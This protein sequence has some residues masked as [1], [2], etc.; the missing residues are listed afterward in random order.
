MLR[1]HSGK[2]VFP[3]MA[4]TA[5]ARLGDIPDGRRV[6]APPEGAAP[7]ATSASA[8]AGEF[9]L[10]LAPAP[11]PSGWRPWVGKVF[12]FQPD[13]SLA[14]TVGRPRLFL[15][16]IVPVGDFDDL[17][18]TVVSA[19][20]DPASSALVAGGLAFPDARGPMR[21]LKGVTVVDRATSV[22]TLDL[23]KWPNPLGFDP[24]ADGARAAEWMRSLLPPALRA[25]R[26]SVQWSSSCCVGAVA[27]RPPDVLSAAFRLLLDERLDEGRRVR[28]LRG[29]NAAVL[30]AMGA[31]GMRQHGTGMPVDPR[32]GLCTQ[33]SYLSPPRLPKGMA[34]PLGP[35]RWLE[36]PGEERA[37]TARLLSELPPDEGKAPARTGGK[38]TRAVRAAGPCPA[39]ACLPAP[40]DSVV[41]SL[42]RPEGADIVPLALARLA[43]RTRLLEGHR[44]RGSGR[45]L[46]CF[47]GWAARLV[48]DLLCLARARAA[49]GRQG[50][51][52]FRAWAGGVPEGHRNAWAVVLHSTLFYALGGGGL[53]ERG[54]GSCREAMLAVGGPLLGED[55]VRREWFAE[56]AHG[57]VSDRVTRSLSGER[58][59]WRGRLKCLVYGYGAETV[60]A[61]LGVHPGECGILG[62]SSLG[63]R[64]LRRRTAR[65][66]AGA[67]P[68][69]ALSS[70]S[71]GR[72]A[73]AAAMRAGGAGRAEIARACGRSESWVSSLRLPPPPRSGREGD[74]AA[75]A[76]R[77][78][79][80]GGCVRRVAAAVGRSS[81]WVCGNT[82]APN[83]RTARTDRI[84]PVPPPDA[85][86]TDA[87]PVAT[88]KGYLRLGGDT[89]TIS[90]D[91]DRNR[92]PS[93]K[94]VIACPR[95]RGLTDPRP[96]WA[97]A[98]IPVPPS[99]PTDSPDW[100]REGRA[101][102]RRDGVRAW[103]SPAGVWMRLSLNDVPQRAALFG[104][105]REDILEH[106]RLALEANR[107]AERVEAGR[108]SADRAYAA[109]RQGGGISCGIGG[110][111]V[112]IPPEPDPRLVPGTFDWWSDRSSELRGLLGRRD[113]RAGLEAFRMAEPLAF[114]AM[115][116]SAPVPGR[117]GAA[118]LR[119]AE[120]A[121]G[122]EARERERRMARRV[123]R[124][125]M[126]GFGP[127]PAG[128]VS[129][130]RAPTRRGVG[131]AGWEERFR[132]PADDWDR[133]AKSL[134]PDPDT[135]RDPW[136]RVPRRRVHPLRR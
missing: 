104:A 27:G 124:A 54:E 43:R 23:D 132:R 46:A 17:H 31:A 89:Y 5:L 86:F 18:R 122:R 108:T 134:G 118:A 22:L 109:W 116:L 24:R 55:W 93:K 91:M 103:V 96:D 135:D 14:A 61:S 21:R 8:P 62:L 119:E 6:A 52:E 20:R 13:G 68:R 94:E 28:L 33:V 121:A 127:V 129:D 45:R 29:A 78:R 19:G 9:L 115:V 60:R 100:N 99:P 48:L 42:S 57:S 125:A 30:A 130:L 82:R 110:G 101:A 117:E 84:A 79:D 69:A 72:K 53:D 95:A 40:P 90:P 73:R 81:G 133:L 74:L 50:V 128:K 111:M 66:A 107:Q 105:A 39:P 1:T 112:E 56:G 44:E 11:L 7:S 26:A 80:G 51:E 102:R 77:L 34:D 63:D 120:M 97:D 2:T 47:G 92:I 36:L 98:S 88:S 114:A 67:V 131:K 35:A 3:A 71:D 75:R 113:W 106:R 10:R 87:H 59:E 32:L 64:T 126:L 83:A 38:G 15:P 58:V 25:A 85:A 49:W 37:C 136:E 41:A 70:E 65:R 4:L 123:R 76:Q 12:S 16:E